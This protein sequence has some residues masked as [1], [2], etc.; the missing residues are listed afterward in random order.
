[1]LTT[2]SIGASVLRSA[3]SSVTST[4]TA[5]TGTGAS[6]SCRGQQFGGVAVAVGDDDL[7]DTGQSRRG[8]DRHGAHRAGAAQGENSHGVLLAGGCCSTYRRRLSR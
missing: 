6:A 2:R 4:V 3:A 1:M 7:L 5:R 8:A